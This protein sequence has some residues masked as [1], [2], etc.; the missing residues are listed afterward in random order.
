MRFRDKIPSVY[1]LASARNGTI[2]IGVTSDLHSRIGQHK[3]HLIEGFT[4]KYGV[5]RLVYYEQHDSMDAAIRR[6][7]TLKEWR[8]TWKI[9]L[10]EGM[11]PEWL[12]L[13]DDSSGTLL[14]GPAD[15]A[16]RSH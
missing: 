6:E 9:R 14:D 7:K 8:R 3:Q 4:Q 13:F 11:N 10:I 15:V 2:Y 5:T 12:E 1:N 16:R